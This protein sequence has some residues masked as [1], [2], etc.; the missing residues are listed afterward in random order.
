MPEIIALKKKSTLEAQHSPEVKES[1]V[2]IIEDSEM[3]K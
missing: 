1:N 2:R 3:S